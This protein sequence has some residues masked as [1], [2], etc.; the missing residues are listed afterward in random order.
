MTKSDSL[1]KS[2]VAKITDYKPEKVIVFGSLVKGT[3]SKDSD[4]DLAI[5]KKTN[6]PFYRRAADVRKML[7]SRIPLDVF[8][9]TPKEYE[10][11]EKTNEL[12]A[13][14]DRTGRI[15]YGSAS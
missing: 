15:V 14:I 1:I 10:E 3:W 4:I 7:R 5:I 13:E 6:Q 8:V 9:F 12:V 11:A 2:L